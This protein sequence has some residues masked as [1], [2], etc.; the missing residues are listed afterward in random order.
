[1]FCIEE[2]V[3]REILDSRGNPTLEVDCILDGGVGG[4]AAVPS[5]ASTGEREALELRDGGKRYRGK[6]VSK[7]VGH[8]MDEIGPTMRGLDARDQARIDRALI[9]LDGTPDKS[10]LGANALLGVS[11]AVAKAAAEASGLPPYAYL[12]GPAATVLPVPL[13]N[14]LNGGAHADNSVDIQEFMIVPMGFETFPEALQAGVE[15]Y[16]T[17]K[18]VLKGRKLVTAVGDEGGFAPDL[19]SNREA[20]DLLMQAI[21]KAGYT[22]GRQVGLALDVA[23]SELVE[24]KGCKNVK[25]ALA[26]EGK[27]GLASSDL[28]ALYREWLDAYPLVSIEDGLAENDHA[29]WKELT[30][31]LGSR[32]QLVGDDLFVTNPEILA[33]GIAEGMANALLVKV[34]QIGTLT[35]TLEAVDMAKRNAYANILSHRSGETEDTTIADLA[36]ATRAGQIKT[37]APCRSDRVAK[38]NR[39]LRIAEELDVVA[40]YPGAAAFPRW[41]P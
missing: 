24:G 39:L 16:H 4:R 14:V 12:G 23:A 32:V 35:E 38:Y 6:G 37:G 18:D 31:E 36:V 40:T 17:L 27:K 19:K 11:L 7:A 28:I 22:P 33:K 2:I 20:L 1:M 3:A 29:G 25:Y 26:G 10:R 30:R 41:S 34:N 13:L 15:I 5:G 9:E 8:V 21:E